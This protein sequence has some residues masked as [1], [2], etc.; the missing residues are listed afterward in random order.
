MAGA[1]CDEIRQ[2]ERRG[3]TERRGEVWAKTT[4]AGRQNL[5]TIK[6]FEAQRA[7]PDVDQMG[8]HWASKCAPTVSALD[9]VTVV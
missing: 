9:G 6:V 1:T 4:T 2:K 8:E 3:E 7:L 5:K